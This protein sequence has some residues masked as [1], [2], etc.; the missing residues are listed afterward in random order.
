MP[1]QIKLLSEFPGARLP[2]ETGQ[3]YAENALVKA[4]AAF[5]LTAA[6][7]I[8]L[9]PRL[10]DLKTRFPPTQTVRGLCGERSNG[11][12]QLNR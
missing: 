2:D 10:T 6:L 1:F 11:V 3:T 4:R 7:A 8:Q 12:F 9:S 5:S